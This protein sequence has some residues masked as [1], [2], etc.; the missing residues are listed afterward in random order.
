MKNEI[1]I[2]TKEQLEKLLDKQKELAFDA[3]DKNYPCP[4]PDLPE[5]VTVPNED[6]ILK[7]LQEFKST[8]IHPFR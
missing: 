2:L 5:P 8:E 4:T 7:A 1:Y 6:E 3:C